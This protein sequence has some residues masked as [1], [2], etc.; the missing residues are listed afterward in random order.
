[1]YIFHTKYIF[2]LS[3]Y[4]Y[5]VHLYFKYII[6]PC[7]LYI[8][9]P[10]TLYIFMP[11]ISLCHVHCTYSYQVDLLVMYT[12]IPSTLYIFMPSIFLCHVHIH[13][14]YTFEPSTHSS[15]E[16]A[17]SATLA[18]MSDKGTPLPCKIDSSKPCLTFALKPL[19]ILTD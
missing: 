1:M 2:I 9:V 10:S 17:E 11:S 7:T 6:L 4:L 13:T 14:K 5:Q 12:F 16:M 15:T 3:T 18:A 8:S 19:F